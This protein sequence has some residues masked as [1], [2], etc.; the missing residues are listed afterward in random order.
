M[1]T[2]QEKEFIFWW[3][4]NRLRRK[5]VY[6]QLAVGL[7]FGVF[8]AAAT[9]INYFSGWYTRANMQIGVSSSGVMVILVG[10]LL[11]VVF[12]VVFSARHKWEMNEQ[13]YR[14]LI[15]RNKVS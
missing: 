10:L 12:I 13:H 11:I 15:S 14:E 2:D 7:P 6:R 4:Q 9:G 8:L 1:L 3:E 5:K